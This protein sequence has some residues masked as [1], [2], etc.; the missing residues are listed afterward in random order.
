MNIS[1]E[2]RQR[3]WGPVSEKPDA[4]LEESGMFKYTIQYELKYKSD[5]EPFSTGEEEGILG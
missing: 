2:E 5:V 1:N 4:E 3:E